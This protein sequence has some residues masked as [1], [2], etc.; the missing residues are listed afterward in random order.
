MGPIIPAE[1]YEGVIAALDR[2]TPA[3]VFTHWTL[4]PVAVAV[5]V[6]LAIAY[7]QGVRRLGRPWPP[8]RSVIFGV[9]L[10]LLLWTSCGYLG[11]YAG[12]LF[13][14]WTAQSLVLWLVVPVVLLFGHPVQLARAAAP[15]RTA[16][17]LATRS[18]RLVS[19]PF[20]SPALVPI[21]SFG[22]FFGPV[23]GLAIGVPLFGWVLQLLLVVVGAGMAL[24]LVGLDDDQVSTN[25]AGMALGIG[26]FELVIDAVP[27]IVMRLSDTL[28]ST[29]FDHRAAHGWA[30]NPL[31]DQRTGGSIMW[32][33]AEI[34]DLPF[35]ILGYRRW[36]RIDAKDAERVDAVLETQRQQRRALTPADAP[37]SA[38]D[39][40]VPW[41]VDDPTMQARMRR[42]QD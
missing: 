20:V 27:G 25:L 34:I 26:M 6:V 23:P 42:R 5:A 21:L 40:D 32:F 33:I 18:V 15:V 9:G 37:D 3:T 22:I 28:L 35:L 24:W 38:T 7:V 12:S 17:I 11:A 4:Q 41:W 16:R 13:W 1:H 19:N 31:S 2:P 39:R 30:P 14:A 8:G 36:R 10:A 29:F